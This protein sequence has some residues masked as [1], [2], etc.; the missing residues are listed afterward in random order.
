LTP[1]TGGSGDTEEGNTVEP[2]QTIEAA[3][4]T[5]PSEV[6]AQAAPQAEGKRTQLKIVRE[7]I[8]YLSA[9]LGNFRRNHEASIKRLEKQVASLRS[10]LAPQSISNDVANFRKSQEARAKRLE[11]QVAT[12]RLELAALKRSIAKDAAR[13]HARQ[14][15]TLSRILAK[16]SAK[17]KP[18]KPTK[19]TKSSKS[20]KKR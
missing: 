9:D 5:Q 17:P 2:M 6:P 15:A 4:P 7:N 14:E 8:Q 20:T 12:L 18:S 3:P 13:G 16:V 11:K 1:E 10:E 19:P